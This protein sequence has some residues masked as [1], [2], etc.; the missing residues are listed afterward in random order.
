DKAVL[1]G[2]SAGGLNAQHTGLNRPDKETHIKLSGAYPA[3]HNVIGQKLHKHGMYLLE[4]KPG[5]IIKKIA[6]R[7]PKQRQR[8]S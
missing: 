3:V 6:V 7:Q 5:L 1:F 4:K 2:Y 8:R